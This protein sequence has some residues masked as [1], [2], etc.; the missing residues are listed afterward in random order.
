MLRNLC[1]PFS[2]NSVNQRKYS[3]IVKGK[4]KLIKLKFIL[5]HGYSFIPGGLNGELADM[6]RICTDTIL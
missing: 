4:K 5:F 2:S 1:F 3:S 6:I